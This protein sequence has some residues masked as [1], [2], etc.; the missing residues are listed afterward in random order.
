[1]SMS[2]GRSRIK[3]RPPRSRDS[4]DVNFD[5]SWSV[6]STAMQEMYR[7]NA[8]RLSYEELYRTAYTLVLKKHAA[9]LYNSFKE[10]VGQHLRDVVDSE[11]V[12]LSTNIIAVN[13][14]GRSDIVDGLVPS[15]FALAAD[16]AEAGIQ[17]LK[18]VKQQ[19]DDHCLCMRMI[20]DILMYMDRVYC[21]ELQLPLI[22]DA[23]LALFR[24]NVVRNDESHVGEYIYSIILG[25]IKLERDGDIVDT[26][27]IKSIVVMLE[28]LTEDKLD[29][30]SVYSRSF[31]PIFLQSSVEFYISEAARLLQECDSSQYL[32]KTEKRLQEEY[33]RSMSY[34][35]V[36][37]EPKIT[38]I[39]EENLI[40]KNVNAVIEFDQSGLTFMIE[41]NKIDDL[42]RLYA[43][44]KRVD[45]E[46][47][48]LRNALMT[49]VVNQGNNVN[50]DV[51]EELNKQDKSKNGGASQ[52]L[53]TVAAFKWV[54][55]V[56]ALKEKYDKILNDAMDGD[57]QIQTSLTNAFSSFINRINRCSEFL[58][59]FLDDNLK[60]GLKGKTEDEAEL[61]L[62]RAIT[63][64]R[65]ISD[66]DMF[67]TYYKTHLAK[68]LLGGRSVSD[69]AERLMIAKLK[70]EVGFSFT[71]KLEGMF[72][73]MKVSNDMM[74]DYKAHVQT[75]DPDRKTEL[76][77]SVLTSTN[78]PVNL[79]HTESRTCIFPPELDRIQKSFEKFYTDRHSGRV[80]TWNPNMGNADLRVSF[81]KRKHEINVS[82]YGMVI[83][84]LF[85]N[86]ADGQSLLF[87]DIKAA[88]SIPE[89]ELIRNL[90]SL[91]V[92][93][94]TRILIK[95]P[96]SKNI[97]PTDRFTFNNSFESQYV[98]IK[99][100]TVAYINK[101]ETD[102][103]RKETM[104]KIDSLR[105][106][107][108]DAA[109]V[110]IM[111]ARKILEH[112]ILVAEV[113]SQLAS[114][115]H[116]DAA[117]IKK[118]ID[119]LLEREYIERSSENRHLYHYLA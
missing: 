4:A 101:T 10:F 92:V 55:G 26:A 22:Y 102:H 70:L 43:L 9:K 114:R 69:D 48:D 24:D 94:K 95:E 21:K 111:K 90:Q 1:M 68:R 71:T 19:W 16:Q 38:K 58:S 99:I 88:T 72:K 78:W 30:E 80:L 33:E 17:F 64:F 54:E 23:G 89:N 91:S 46:K 104:E 65:Y 13:G 57:N 37:S 106:Y 14:M 27:M 110:R 3:M 44:C 119:A 75:A 18:I 29:G 20:S 25:Q 7:K 77:V 40:T 73:D 76:F 107:L 84:L 8:S 83:L 62:N 12:P 11:L 56:L 98:R 32:I 52:N 113:G 28:S 61:V 15:S 60:K 97:K 74:Q 51:L 86:L 85:N 39:V 47:T 79:S 116:P 82:T 63:L 45:P 81:R 35:S 96:M 6:L 93:P 103:E 36:I 100:P 66:K 108:T 5:E 41:N 34:L 50:Q 112:N 67:E 109:I 59:L 115:F 117:L 105:K 42:K 49:R 87:D 31:E 2:S 118:R 53:A